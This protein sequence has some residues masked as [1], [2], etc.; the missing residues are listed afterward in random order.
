MNGRAEVDK[1]GAEVDKCGMEVD[2]CGA[3]SP[4]LTGG[5]KTRCIW[6]AGLRH[7][8]DDD[9]VAWREEAEASPPSTKV[10][11]DDWW[12]LRQ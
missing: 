7:S 2:K 3:I 1:C 9:A 12:D 11:V 10:H 6:T 8:L 4:V 5:L